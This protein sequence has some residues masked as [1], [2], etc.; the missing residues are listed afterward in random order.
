MDNDSYWAEVVADTA[1]FL[2]KTKTSESNKIEITENIED[3]TF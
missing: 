1:Q 2:S 3:V